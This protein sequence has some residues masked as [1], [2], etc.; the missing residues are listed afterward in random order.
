MKLHDR[1]LCTRELHIETKD[2]IYIRQK[3]TEYLTS[4]NL[5]TL[6]E[7]IVFVSDRGTNMKKA[8]EPYMNS[9]CFAH[10]L[11]NMV[12]KMFDAVPGIV[13]NVKSL[14]KYFK[15]TGLSSA[16]EN[17]LKSYIKTRWNTIYYMMKSLI[18]NWDDVVSILTMKNEMHRM[19]NIDKNTIM[20]LCDFVKVFEEATNE[21]EA[22]KSPTLHL[23]I[24]WYFKLLKYMEFVGV[25]SAI[26]SDM[27][28]VGRQYLQNN[29]ASHL[30]KFQKIAVFLCPSMKSLKMY[31]RQQRTEIIECARNLMSEK[32]ANS[33]NETQRRENTGNNNNSNSNPCSN[34]SS[35]LQMFRDDSFNDDDDF[36]D[37]EKYVSMHIKSADDSVNDLLAWW[38]HH[39]TMLPQLFKLACFIFSIPAS[40]AAVERVF[41]LAGL[42]IKNRPNLNPSTLD[43]LLLLKSNH[44]LFDA[45]KDQV[46]M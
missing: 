41:S 38:A 24:P 6:I 33:S 1:I 19:N 26:V 29:I 4:F 22:S 36:D 45:A 20:M 16:L 7:N 21:I 40:S 34:T 25:D 37:I 3:L 43:D 9:H 44:D 12:V 27:K 23:V 5:E 35:A 32:F 31:N 42:T 17:S 10:M 11:H 14:V 46:P 8:V 30:S 13:D 39:K 28:S 15:V 2:G 18:D